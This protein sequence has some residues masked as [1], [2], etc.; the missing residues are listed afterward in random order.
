MGAGKTTLAKGMVEGYGSASAE[1]V[2]SPTF[3]IV[4]EYRAGRIVYHLDLYRLATE[5]EV[6]AIGLDDLLDAVEAGDALMLVEWGERFQ[7]LWPRNTWRVAIT[8]REEDREVKMFP[9]PTR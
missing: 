5:Q 2:S 1:D 6:R 9:G 7:R 4:H 8:V 3:P